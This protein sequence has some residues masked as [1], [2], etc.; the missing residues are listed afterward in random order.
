MRNTDM[1]I[2]YQKT[3]WTGHIGVVKNDDCACMISIAPEGLFKG[4]SAVFMG[5]DPALTWEEAWRTRQFTIVA[6]ALLHPQLPKAGRAEV[7]GIFLEQLNS[8]GAS[9]QKGIG[10]GRVLWLSLRGAKK[11]NA[12]IDFTITPELDYSEEWAK[13]EAAAT[14]AE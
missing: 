8:E 6:K 13:T 9:R 10:F 14:P 12:V 11:N 7:L 2:V 3:R 5:F 1:P 4:W